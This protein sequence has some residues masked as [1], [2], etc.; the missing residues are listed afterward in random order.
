LFAAACEAA[1]GSNSISSY[2]LLD[3]G[4]YHRGKHTETSS[5]GAAQG[6]GV[7]PWTNP[8]AYIEESSVFRLQNVTT[9]LLMMHCRK[10]PQVPFEQAVELFTGL[11]RAGKSVWLLEYDNG[12][13]TLEGQ[14]AMD[15]T[16]RLQQFFDHY[17]MGTP[18][19]VWMT[20]GIP[21]NLKGTMTGYEIDSTGNCS[22]TCKIC[23]SFH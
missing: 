18:A 21:A 22:I 16:F 11:K 9:P 13:H 20:A 2:G 6:I 15:F 7:T 5:Q 19:P 3:G 23:N 8:A 1:G 4:G 17:L 12:G 14:E 10:D